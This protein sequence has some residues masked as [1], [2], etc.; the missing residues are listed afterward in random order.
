MTEPISVVQPDDAAIASQLLS[1]LRQQTGVPGLEYAESPSRITGGQETITYGFSLAVPPENL[2]GQL[3]LR[4]FPREGASRQGGREAAFQNALADLGYPIPRVVA[5]FDG[6]ADSG[7]DNRA[8][9]VME[10]VVGTPMMDEATL[11][12]ANI[13]RLIG[14]LAKVH[15]RLHQA[16]SAPV[17]EAVAKAG[18]SQDQFSFDGRMNFMQRYFEGDAFNA[19]RPVHDWLVANR[20]SEQESPAVCHGDF[21]PGNIMVKDGEVTGVIDWPGAAFADPEFDVGTTLVLI[22]AGAGELEPEVRSM[23]VQ[24]AEMYLRMYNEIKPLSAEKVDYYEALRSFRA[25]TRATALLTPGVDPA[26][27]PRDQYPWAGEFAMHQLQ[28]RLKQITGVD[29][30]L[31]GS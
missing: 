4:I 12:P 7:I 31:P 20:P 25:F 16:P 8:F 18:F 1:A 21:H 24:I 9:N 30:P 19:I 15:V 26:L 10:R 2:A 28:S 13:E 23:V 29:L 22:K 5:Q 27:A 3:I 6:A 17:I 11:D 14:W